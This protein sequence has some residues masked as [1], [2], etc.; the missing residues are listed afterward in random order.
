MCVRE[1]EIE[2]PYGVVSIKDENICSIK[3]KPIHNF[4]V[5]AGI[6]LLEPECIDLIPENEFF[7]MTSLFEKAIAEKYKAISFPLME[8]WLDIGHLNEYERAN[9]DILDI[10]KY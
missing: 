7:D 1:Y 5:N 3:E 6:Y 9:K 10:D 8:Y 2:V 4:Y